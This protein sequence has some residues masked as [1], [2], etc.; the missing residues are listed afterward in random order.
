MATY[1]KQFLSGSTDGA[2]IKVGATSGGGSGTAVHTS[3]ATLIDEMW[4]YAV[5]T[6]TS[7]RKLTVEFG[8]TTSPDNLIEQTI[9]PESGLV[10]VIP[11]L[12]LSGGKTISAFAASA[13]KILLLGFAN[14]I[15]N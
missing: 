14:Q 4:I 13:D 7:A 11:G 9:Q 2:P 15:T 8:G 1:T 3:H 10:L 12:P 5:N 6:D